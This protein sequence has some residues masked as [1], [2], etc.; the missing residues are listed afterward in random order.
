MRKANNK[1]WI[2]DL[3][4]WL[5]TELITGK[6][7]RF[8]RTIAVSFNEN[9]IQ[10]A[11]ARNIW[12]RAKLLNVT[13]IYIPR[14]YGTEEKR[15]NFIVLEVNKYIEQYGTRLTRYVLG[16]GSSG[17]AFRA[18][19]LPPMPG[20]EQARAIRWEA[21]KR[22]P[23]GL[24]NAYF[25]YHLTRTESTATGDSILVS[26]IAVSKNEVDTMM[27]SLKPAKFKISAVYHEL[28]AIGH[29]LPYIKNYDAGKTYALINIKKERS[30]I[31]YY[32]GKRLEFM[33][34]SSVGSSTVSDSPGDTK[35]E[36]FAK[37]LVNEIQ[38][39]L[40]YYVGQFSNTSTDMVFVYGD[41]SY[42]DDLIKNLSDHFEIEFK[43]FPLDYLAESKVCREEFHDQIPVSLSA[44]AL[45]MIDYDLIDFLPPRA[46]EQHASARYT[47]L[48]VPAFVFFA[49]LLLAAGALMKYRDDIKSAWLASSMAQIV[50]FENSQPV[51]MYNQIKRQMVTDKEIL[52]TLDQEPTYLHLNLKELS[53]ITPRQIKL[54]LYDLEEAERDKSLMLSGWATSSDPPPEVVLAEFVVRLESSPF[55]EN[56]ALDKHS[57]SNKGGLFTIDFQISLDA[58]L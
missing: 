30:E 44:V 19:S 22:I 7:Y 47:R 52:N 16:V 33:S 46:K 2:S 3:A 26:L 31:S 38:T 36:I 20:R 57:K 8:G 1:K 51:I 39:S 54:N 34:I 23:F 29:L 18:I 24:D 56:V 41:L 49:A 55:F 10:M 32:R 13:K 53:R 58:I 6:H 43:R 50:K 25:G 9:S 45:A 42:S 17:S 48:A 40:D 15:R 37:S 12:H 11:T 28:E 5:R 21:D 4:A 14:S 27:H 35:Y